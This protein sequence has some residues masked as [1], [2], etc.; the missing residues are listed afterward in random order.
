MSR[1]ERGRTGCTEGGEVQVPFG[2]KEAGGVALR[3][4]P[5]SRQ[6]SDSAGSCMLVTLLCLSFVPK[7]KGR[8]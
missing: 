6:G 1:V 8:Q 7:V 3:V 4:R 5:R 2:W